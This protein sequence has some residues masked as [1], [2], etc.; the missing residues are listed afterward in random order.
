[1]IIATIKY[2]RSAEYDLSNDEEKRTAA[3]GQMQWI[4]YQA[5]SERGN[6][7]LLLCCCRYVWNILCRNIVCIKN[8]IIFITNVGEQRRAG[9]GEQ[10]LGEASRGEWSRGAQKENV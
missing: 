4:K 2:E 5:L 8:K 10:S 3:A 1:M 7:I 6:L 9:C